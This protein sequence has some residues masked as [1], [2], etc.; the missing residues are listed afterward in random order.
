M[1]AVE[2]TSGT[3]DFTIPGIS[4]PCKTWY[5]VFG[6]LSSSSK[7]PLVIL[8]G[9]PGVPHSY[10]LPLQDIT[11]MYGTP[12]IMYDQMGCGNSTHLPEKVHDGDFWTVQL[13]LDELDNLLLELKIQDD[14]DLL[15][16]S[17]GGMLAAC[18]AI[19]QPKGLR[20]LIIA[21]SPASMKLW[22][23]AADRLREELPPQLQATLTRCEKEGKTESEEYEKA[24]DV[25]YER[26]LCRV[27]P[28]PEELQKSFA[29][30][31]KDPTVMMTMNGPSE[32]FITGTL[33]TWS[34]IEELHKIAVPTLLINGRYDEAQDEVVEPFF[35]RIPKV[36]WF[37]FAES[38]HVSKVFLYG[39]CRVIQ[40]LS[41]R[42]TVLGRPLRVRSHRAFGDEW[43]TRAL[44]SF[45]N[46]RRG[47]NS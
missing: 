5:T 16:Q 9:G 42:T 31:K 39:S 38:S 21:D 23:E 33:K 28:M 43:L 20:R 4:S 11:K 18:H 2:D 1:A 34:I 10:M 13:F 17:W 15:G 24:V 37:R 25:Y 45:R 7:R 44:C 12:V 19:R 32:F 26:H 47:G 3:L 6:S 41:A 40:R 22:V 35:E 14:Y 46:L 29:D 30:M 27:K 36:K 8:H